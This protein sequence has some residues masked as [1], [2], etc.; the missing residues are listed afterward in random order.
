MAGV[1]PP[2]LADA[3]RPVLGELVDETIAAIGREI[4]EYRRPLEGDFGRALRLGVDRALTRF[5]D[6]IA[7]P[8]TTDR[9]AYGP[10]YVELGRGEQRSGRGLDVLLSAYRIGAGRAW[11][12]FSRAAD[13]A[14][15]DSET[16]IALAS[17]IFSYI[18]AISAES[19]DGYA[20]EQSRYAGERD[21][22]R[23]ALIRLLS[24]EGVGVEELADVAATAGWPLPGTLAAIVAPDDA[25]RE[26]ARIGPDLV[27]TAQDGLAVGF[28]ADPDA[29]GRRAQFAALLETT[30]VALGPTVAPPRAP[31]SLARAQATHRLLAAGRLARGTTGLVVSADHLLAILLHADDPALSADLAAGALAPLDDLPPGPRAKLA[32]TLRAWLDDPGHVQHVAGVLDVHPQTVRY[33]VAQLRERFGERLDDPEARFELAVALRV[34]SG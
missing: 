30:T 1:L 22:R 4:P 32:A 19:V 8:T 18:D 13:A 11:Q 5:V 15:H 31:H 24:T 16:L 28:L 10:I 33:R 29:P 34:S 26:L 25:V 6:A 12:R 7:E 3:L 27:L 23:R 21:R 2:S 17:E 9:F 20:E 14:G